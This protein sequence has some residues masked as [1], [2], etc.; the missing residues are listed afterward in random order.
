MWTYRVG[1]ADQA[2]NG[3]SFFSSIEVA[4]QNVGIAFRR[5]LGNSLGYEQCALFARF[6]GFVIEMGIENVERAVAGFVSE[7]SPSTNSNDLV[8]PVS[9]TNF[10]SFRKPERIGFEDFELAF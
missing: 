3:L 7:M 1:F 9:R 2:E 6:L 5:S 8:A 4:H 10:R